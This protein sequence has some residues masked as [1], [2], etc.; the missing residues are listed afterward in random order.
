MT[1]P[2]ADMLTRIRNQIRVF[3]KEVEIPFSRI[4]EGIAKVLKEQDYIKDYTVLSKNNRKFLNLQLKYLK[5]GKNRI[6]DLKRVSKPGLRTYAGK[7][8]LPKIIANRGMVILS[9][10]SGIMVDREAKE[11]GV[12]GE[13]LCRIW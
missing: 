1:D 6:S 5:N 10:S 8:K 9:T 7:E 4:K 2:I 11:K 13:I 12:G 3:G